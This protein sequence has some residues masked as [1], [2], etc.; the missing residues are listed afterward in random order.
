MDSRRSCN[1][2]TLN[3]PTGTYGRGCCSDG[4][5]K[6]DVSPGDG[7]SGMRMMF[8]V[9][10]AADGGGADIPVVMAMSV[11]IRSSSAKPVNVTES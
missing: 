5:G 1:I 8:V 4:A 11:N 3:A 2:G 9:S 10:D 6:R 7:D